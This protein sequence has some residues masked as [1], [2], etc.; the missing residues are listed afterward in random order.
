MRSTKKPVFK[1]GDANWID[2]L[3]TMRKQYNNR[4]HSSFKITP[5]QASFKKKEGYV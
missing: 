4:K 3:V 5:I 2:V 1:S